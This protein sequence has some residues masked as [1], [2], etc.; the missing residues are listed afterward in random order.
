MKR[1]VKSG[2]RGAATL[3]LFALVFTA[4]MAGTY[5]LTRDTVRKNELDAKV[6][7]LAQVLPAGSYDNALL[8]DA[9]VVPKADAA[10]LGNDTE[11]RIYLAKKAG[12]TVGAVVEATAP[13]GYAGRIR[14]LIGVDAAGRVLGV[15]VVSHKE[16]PGLGDYIDAAKSDWITQFR[17]KSTSNPGNALWKV[18]KDGGAF[19]SRAGATISPRA[20]VTAIHATLVYVDAHRN[21]LFGALH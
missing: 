21:Q 1:M 2:V 20:V 17:Y 6:A 15:R 7:L 9:V 11:S 5:A 16:T 8:D 12:K 14:L 19:D 13:D 10:R 4:L 18:K 3:A